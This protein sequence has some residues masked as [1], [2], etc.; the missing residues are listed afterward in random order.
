MGDK[1]SFGVYSA[2]A[3]SKWIVRECCWILQSFGV[4]VP[5]SYGFGAEGLVLVYKMVIDES[6]SLLQ[7]LSGHSLSS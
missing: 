1:I 3:V 2:I 7:I 6:T 5:R 4:R